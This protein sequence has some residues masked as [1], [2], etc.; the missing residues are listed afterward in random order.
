VLVTTSLALAEATRA[1]VERQLALLERAEATRHSI[2]EYSAII[3]TETLEAATEIANRF[4]TEHLQ[5]VTRQNDA[6]LARIRHA[7]AVFLGPY[8]PVPVGDYFAG[9]SHVL[10]TGGTAKFFGPLSCNDFIK[11]SSL[12]EYDPE[13]LAEDAPKVRDFATHEGLTAHARAIMIRGE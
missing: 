5:I 10:P 13:G 2:D 7:G 11:A 9:P 3:V 8:A 1:E 6:C 4:A 12:I